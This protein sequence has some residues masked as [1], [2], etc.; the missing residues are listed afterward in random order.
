M[1]RIERKP[2][3]DYFL[4]R[5]QQLIWR[6][7]VSVFD[8][9][10]YLSHP[11]VAAVLLFV[12]LAIGSIF[13]RVSFVLLLTELLMLAGLYLHTLFV[14]R[15]VV[16][17]RVLPRKT[18]REHDVAEVIVEIQNR[19]GFSISGLLVED[20]FGLTKESLV[21]LAPHQIAANSMV[22]H[23]Y[24][25]VCDAGMGTHKVGP[26]TVRITDP[27]GI[28]EFRIIE[29][30]IQ[31]AEVY[32]FVDRIPDVHVVP[33]S[34]SSRYGNY[35]VASRGL[36]V[37]FSG[38]RPYSKGDSLRH[39]AWKLS[40]RGQGLF[41]KEFEKVVNCDVNIVL[42]LSPQWQVGR[43]PTSTW[44]AAKDV[45]LSLI[46]QQL[47]VGNSVAFYSEDSFIEPGSGSDHFHYLAKHVASLKPTYPGGGEGL[48]ID[49]KPVLGKYRDFYARGSNVFYITPYNIGEFKRSESWLRRLQAEGFH[50]TCVFIDTNTYWLRFL[51][52]VSTGLLIGTKLIQG[53]D[54]DV[55]KLERLGIATFVVKD[56][57]SLRQTFR[58][59]VSPLSAVQAKE[60]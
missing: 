42:N 36:S 1:I 33:S 32:P 52:S 57:E 15:K 54:D 30:A 56:K 21:K 35:E 16:V 6:T 44:E 18:L 10:R 31:E 58:R 22:R 4:R 24:K 7:D 55:A 26:L 5:K 38:V 37:N 11:S 45:S 43:G 29:D 48:P 50:V 12:L 13:S 53:I 49:P 46:Q 17:K 47:D 3:Q 25:R 9:R 51:E 23:P 34:Q 27:I 41:V 14:A 59:N 60:S 20:V 8:S 2:L 19:S 28:F 39:I 40:M